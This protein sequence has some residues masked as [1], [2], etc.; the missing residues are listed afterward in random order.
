M[1]EGIPLTMQPLIK[2]NISRF[3]TLEEF[4]R[5]LIDL[6]TGLRG[7]KTSAEHIFVVPK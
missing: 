5:I 4:R 7:Q 2:A 6:E 3:T 1:I